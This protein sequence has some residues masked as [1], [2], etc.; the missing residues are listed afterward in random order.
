MLRRHWQITSEIHKKSSITTK[1][2]TSNL[3]SVSNS[4]EKNI[5]V[6]HSI[7]IFTGSLQP[8]LNIFITRSMRL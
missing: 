3:K 4:I 1:N 2:I 8:F 6:K 7:I 5:Y